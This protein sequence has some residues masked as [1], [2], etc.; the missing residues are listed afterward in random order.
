MPA[1]EVPIPAL[2]EK[3]LGNAGAEEWVRLIRR[4]EPLFAR[5]VYRVAMDWGPARAEEIADIVQTICLKLAARNGEVLR[6]LPAESDQSA[7]AY[8]KVMAANSALDHFKAKYADK[9]GRDQTVSLEPHDNLVALYGSHQTTE[10]EILLAQVDAALEADP[11]E[12]R[13]FWL[14]YRQGFTA[15]EIAA[16]PALG[17]TAK[18]VE[19]MIHRLTA[20]VR[21]NLTGGGPPKYAGEGKTGAEAS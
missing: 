12:R 18:G 5:A 6:R 19:S 15:R 7:V 4:L 16:I 21:A 10:R 13:I 1:D 17:L 8:F 2:I 3:C 14:Y 20:A 9:R 11:R